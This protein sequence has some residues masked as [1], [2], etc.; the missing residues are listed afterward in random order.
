MMPLTTQDFPLYAIGNRVY[1]QFDSSPVLTAN[2]D[3]LAADIAA[4]LN[5]EEMQRRSLPRDWR[6]QPSGQYAIFTTYTDYR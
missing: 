1:R 5:T 3:G 6:A 4:R 2:S